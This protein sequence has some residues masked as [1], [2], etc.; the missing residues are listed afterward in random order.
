MLAQAL[1]QL[2]SLYLCDRDRV[3]Y[4]GNAVP[5]VLDQLDAL[6]QAQLKD[7]GRGWVPDDAHTI[8]CCRDM[9]GARG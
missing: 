6:R 1:V 7:V 8:A 3:R 4:V 9:R 2:D 5:E